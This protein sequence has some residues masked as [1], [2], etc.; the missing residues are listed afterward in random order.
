MKNRPYTCGVDVAITAL[1]GPTTL[2]P[3]AA[4]EAL[5]A[6]VRS[7]RHRSPT[8]AGP[9]DVLAI[10]ADQVRTERVHDGDVGDRLNL[11]LE[12]VQAHAAGDIGKPAL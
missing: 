9:S 10:H 8:G 3:D 4:V 7:P 11:W 6:R 2:V 5:A 1:G 12:A